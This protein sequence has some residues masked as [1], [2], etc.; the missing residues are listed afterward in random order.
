MGIRVDISA[1]YNGFS[2]SMDA[3]LNRVGSVSNAISGMGTNASAVF[4]RMG[5]VM[6][7]FG[8]QMDELTSP[9][10]NLKDAFGNFF[11]QYT[12]AN[13]AL[14]SFN[15]VTSAI[16]G[17]GD[18]IEE[19][20]AKNSMLGAILG[21][22]EESMQDMI[23]QAKELGRTT[24]FTASQVTQMQIELSKLGFEKSAISEMT[25]SILA[26]AQAT[27]GDLGDAAAISGAALRMFGASTEEASRY[28]NAM[29]RATTASAL[30]FRTI[31]DNL[32]T[33]GPM[34]YSVGLT[35][36]DTLALFG[37]LKNAG[38]EGSTAMTSLRNIFTKVAQGKIP[39][40]EGGVKTLD[41]FVAKLKEMGDLEPGKS[42]KMIG[43]RGGTQFMTLMQSADS[44]IELRD[45]I[46]MASEQDTTAGMADQMTRNVRGSMAMMQSAWEGFVL[47]FQGV[48]EPWDAVISSIT[49]GITTVTDLMNG[50][51]DAA[52]KHSS[53]EVASMLAVMGYIGT[54]A[55]AYGVVN[56]VKV[57]SARL[58]AEQ[59]RQYMML[60]NALQSVTAIRTEEYAVELR[61]AVQKGVL[62]E[63]QAVELTMLMKKAQAHSALL[64]QEKLS[65][66]TTLATIESEIALT[67]TRLASASSTDKQTL[68]LHLL[69]LERDREIA[70]NSLGIASDRAKRASAEM[71]MLNQQM[72]RLSK[73]GRGL[74]NVLNALG[75]GFLT[76]PYVL[77][78]IAIA[79][80]AYVIYELCTA[81]HTLEEAQKDLNDVLSEH[82]QKLAEEESKE[83]E[84][85]KTIQDKNASLYEQYKAYKNLV[86]ARSVF[87]KYSL[88]DLRNMS[89]EEQDRLFREDNIEREK[90]EMNDRLEAL[91]ELQKRYVSYGSLSSWVV[92]DEDM[93]TEMGA[94][95]G[96]EDVFAG[97]FDKM[98]AWE[99]GRDFTSA[100]IQATEGM[101]QERF[102]NEVYAGI[103]GGFRSAVRDNVSVEG[104]LSFAEEYKA[105]MAEADYAV[106]GA[107]HKEQKKI[108]DEARG[109]V[110]ALADEYK[111][112]L[113]PQVD[114]AQKK[115]DELTKALVGAQGDKKAKIQAELSGARETLEFLKSLM[116]MFSNS[117]LIEKGLIVR[118]EEDVR[119]QS[120]GD[121]SILDI[122]KRYDALEKSVSEYIVKL[123]MARDKLSDIEQSGG[124]LPEFFSSI[125][126]TMGLT[127]DNFTSNIGAS[128]DDVSKRIGELETTYANTTDEIEKN[129]IKVRIEEYKKLLNNI[130]AI[131]SYLLGVVNDPYSINVAINFLQ[132]AIGEKPEF[133]TSFAPQIGQQM[134]GQPQWGIS[135]ED[136]VKASAVGMGFDEAQRRAEEAKKRQKKDDEKKKE[137]EKKLTEKERKEAERLA[138]ESANRRQRLTEIERK[139]E[140]ELTKQAISARHAMRKA[141]IASI[142]NDSQRD[143]ETKAHQHQLALEQIDK[144]EEEMKRRLY[145]Y[146][147]SVWEANNTDKTKK[148]IDT[149]E[150]KAGWQGL[151]LTESQNAELDALRREQMAKRAREIADFYK[152]D[153]QAMRDYLMEYGTY[154]QRKLALTEEY[155]QK[156]AEAKNQGERMTL[157]RERDA[158]LASL[159]AES[160]AM[161]IDWSQS[162]S[163]IGNVLTEIG[164]ETLK[165]VKDYMKTEEFKKLSPESKK[166]YV[167]LANDLRKNGAGGQGNPFN[168]KAWGDVAQNMKAYQD[169][170]L[171]LTDAHRTHA[172][173]VDRLKN[174]QEALKNA[175]EE[176]ERAFLETAVEE[177]KMD[178]EA[179]SVRVH[180]AEDEKNDAQQALTESTNEAT[181]GMENFKSAMGQITSGSLYG[182]ADGVVK[183]VTGLSGAQKG[184]EA[185][186]EIGGIIG[187]ALQIVDLIGDDFAHFVSD[188]I[189][190]I[191][192]TVISV[193]TEFPMM[194]VNTVK[195]VFVNQVKLFDEIGKMFGAGSLMEAVFGG[196]TKHFD[197]AVERWGWLLDTWQDNL[198]YERELMEDAYGSSIMDRQDK[199]EEDIRRTQQAAEEMYRAWAKD[200][201]GLFKHSQGYKANEDARWEY[202]RDYNEEI[203]NQVGNDIVNLFNLS[204]EQLE[205][206]KHHDAQFWQSL[207][208]NARD[209]LDIV[210][211]SEKALEDFQNEARERL[212]NVSFD[213]IES[214]FARLLSDMDS[215]SGDF[216]ENFEAYMRNAVINSLMVSK[217]KKELEG[218]YDKFSQAMA[219]DD[220]L[221]RAEQERLKGEYD[222]IVQRAISER[223]MYA[224]MMGWGNDYQKEGTS[225]RFQTMSQE[226]GDELSGRFTA[227][228]MS[229]EVIRANVVMITERLMQMCAIQATE[230]TH[231]QD[232]RN[233]MITSNSYL[234]DIARYTKM[235]YTDFSS[236]VERIASNTDRL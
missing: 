127:A 34:A 100:M 27:G 145:D 234:D 11:M 55:T 69:N 175:T 102:N 86:N 209:Y 89:Q 171:K 199:A 39:G 42:M 151:E 4:S 26:F 116:E 143:R 22:T 169:S 111:E 104:V 219:S 204:A 50:D 141:R 197:D 161:N 152:A 44:I 79:G 128:A 61:S 194:I 90:K 43:P 196:G 193:M 133:F 198:D 97:L 115:V 222:A 13:L 162:F 201:G 126:G 235:I 81:S 216:A 7:G 192:Q 120:M 231:L 188:L 170:V 154:E 16:R 150:G 78:A 176:T 37:T 180:T 200:G 190:N 226:T 157:E 130:N 156:I 147:K 189:D 124:D 25:A 158:K 94:K 63:T 88:E 165:R 107:N 71:A 54:L 155:E 51:F 84:S 106:Q 121:E 172:D 76:N 62:T 122:G 220:E 212:T 132:G 125:L 228:Q 103:S 28:T 139:R 95:Y 18:T 208:E 213:S 142:E 123:S 19:F 67:R 202:L 184:L 173:A 224:D 73:S 118:V 160:I 229:N 138:I 191:M 164:T 117:D 20:E 80:L 49:A 30:D 223:D 153:L 210:I 221:T 134:W 36:E 129:A 70:Q 206:L 113:A 82:N 236:R 31:R 159:D 10:G 77:A 205:D 35:I 60:G 101:I 52:V 99:S 2:R 215:D 38:I 108:M 40:M 112:G 110:K 66:Q 57:V 85:I 96:Q 135:V 233:M 187:S 140:E 174:A 182:F 137:E 105:I 109:K 217:Y 32:A 178:V 114:D 185:L 9:I 181:E 75:L 47:Q 24:V 59:T 65:A 211:E 163:G 93:W 232:I 21:E 1:V 131:K 53:A 146:N 68:S 12:A 15:Q 8:R 29:A 214:D 45:K 186:G 83:R 136:Q 5:S 41:E 33:F 227:M 166:A 14:K 17:A 92:A 195:S 167:D 207:D 87:S 98:G 148:Y 3:I 119:T 183:I 72:V 225:G 177:A 144:Q 218:W 91:K 74:G 64:A 23:V 203:Y 58:T 179:T 48:T 230:N 149:A 56:G 6:E 168:F 46:R